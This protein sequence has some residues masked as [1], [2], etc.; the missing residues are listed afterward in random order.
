[1]S[2]EREYF[3]ALKTIASFDSPEFIRSK[4]E[5]L[6]GL[7]YPESLEM[8]YNNMIH[9]AKQATYGRRRPKEMK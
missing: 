1:M 6:Y 5:K 9:C 3:D 7:E 4:Y 8:A 2:H